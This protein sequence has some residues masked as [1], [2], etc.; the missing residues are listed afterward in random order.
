[1]PRNNEQVDSRLG[2]VSKNNRASTFARWDEKSWRKKVD[3]ARRE[4]GVGLKFRER[5][6]KSANRQITGRIHRLIKILR[7]VA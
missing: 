5:E 2:N 4:N 1:M 6:E 3:R 7:R